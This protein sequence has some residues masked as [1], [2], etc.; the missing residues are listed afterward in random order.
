MDKYEASVWRVTDPLG[1]NKGVVKR[2]REGKATVSLLA[3]AGAKQLG[4]GNAD[5]YAPCAV[6]GTPD[7][8]EDNGTTDCNTA[9]A[10]S[11][12]ATGSRAACVSAQGMFDMVERLRVG[13]RL[14]APVDDVWDLGSWCEPAR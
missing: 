12:V 3:A 2:I 14:G 1:V 11:A 13:G 7:P 9:S 6:A 5:D 8:G 10:F 4:V